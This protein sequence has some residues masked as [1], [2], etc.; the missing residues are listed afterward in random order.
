MRYLKVSSTLLMIAIVLIW[1]AMIACA[2]TIDYALRSWDR[3]VPAIACL[4]SIILAAICVMISDRC[5]RKA[6]SR[7]EGKHDYK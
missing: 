3:T 5:Y 2:V 7:K 6:I 4:A 1:I